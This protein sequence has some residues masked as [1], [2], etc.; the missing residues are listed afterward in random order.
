MNRLT[1]LG[2]IVCFLIIDT[3]DNRAQPGFQYPIE[4]INFAPQIYFQSW[5][6]E[7]SNG[8]KSKISEVFTP[9]RI[10]SPVR[11]NIDVFFLGG[12]AFSQLKNETNPSLNGFVDSQIRAIIK[13]NDYRWLINIGVNLPS[14]KNSFNSEE[15]QINNFLA[16]TILGFP[17]KRYGRG[18]DFEFGTAY[19]WSLSDRTVVG[20]G[21]GYLKT[22]SYDFLA[23][24]SRRFDPGNEISITGQIN[25]VFDGLQIQGNI[26]TKCFLSDEIDKVPFFKEGAQFEIGG[27]IGF[28]INKFGFS[29]AIKDVIKLENDTFDSQGIAKQVKK[30]FVGNSFWFSSEISYNLSQNMSVASLLNAGIFGESDLQLGSAHIMS[31]GGSLKLMT[32]DNLILN[33]I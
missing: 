15:T 23:T 20:I 29:F 26:L 2:M 13:L 7:D 19:G 30:D 11:Q 4:R 33:A 31:I 32:S 8:E 25:V 28:P 24:D 9:I 1:Y 16:E 17:I 21:I 5:I 3:T 12:T 27:K 10:L 6:I 22:G 14:G 18:F